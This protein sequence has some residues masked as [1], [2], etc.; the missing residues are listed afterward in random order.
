M[1]GKHRIS[2]EQAMLFLSDMRERLTIVPLDSV[3]AY[4]EPS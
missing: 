3:Q 1:P 4:V 2:R